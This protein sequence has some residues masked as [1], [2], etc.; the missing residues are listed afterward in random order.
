MEKLIL[1]IMLFTLIS[2]VWGRAIL[3]LAKNK[4]FKRLCFMV[5]GKVS[6]EFEQVHSF[7]LGLVYVL[8]FV[9]GALILSIIFEFN[10]F[11][12]LPLKNKYIPY[13][14]V[15]IM[16]ELSLSGLIVAFMFMFFPKINWIN[17]IENIP[18]I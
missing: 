15:G 4:I 6:Y 8:V 18:W 10:V 1:T 7:L 17:Q 5:M 14:F 2:I 3:F 13:V 11:L 16:A 12:Y 9:L